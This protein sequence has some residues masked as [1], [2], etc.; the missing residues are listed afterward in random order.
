[1]DGS[2]AGGI[3]YVADSDVLAVKLVKTVETGAGFAKEFG[4]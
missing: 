3:I 1:M 4:L 2:I